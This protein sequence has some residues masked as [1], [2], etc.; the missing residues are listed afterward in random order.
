MKLQEIA[1]YLLEHPGSLKALGA[2]ILAVITLPLIII[3]ARAGQVRRIRNAYDKLI[4][5]QTET[6]T[7]LYRQITTVHEELAKVRGELAMRIAQLKNKSFDLEQSLEQIEKL[8]ARI[9]EL[10]EKETE[11]IKK[12]T[13]NE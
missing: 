4:Q 5:E 1:Q 13:K 12:L 8:Q 7:G 10:E 11:L 2:V 9:K 3:W 6:I